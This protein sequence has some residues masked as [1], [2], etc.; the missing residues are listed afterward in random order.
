MHRMMM[1]P[2]IGGR[3][4][5]RNRNGLA[6]RRIAQSIDNFIKLMNHICHFQDFSV[7]INVFDA[8]VGTTNFNDCAN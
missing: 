5:H 8:L 3:V 1:D 2:K 7:E 4:D 6:N